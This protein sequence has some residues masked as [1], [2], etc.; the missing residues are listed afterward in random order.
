MK[1][2]SFWHQFN[3]GKIEINWDMET[4]RVEL[5]KGMDGTLELAGKKYAL[6]EGENVFVIA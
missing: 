1:K 6:K 4:Y 3:E 2:F 5:P